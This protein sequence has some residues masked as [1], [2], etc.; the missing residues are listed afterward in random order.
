MIRHAGLQDFDRIIELMANFANAAPLDTYHNPEYNLRGVQNYLVTMIQAGCVLVGEIDEQIQGM[1][2]AQ[3]CPDPW[4]NHV[5]ML[6]EVAWWVE[7]AYR[8][9][10][11]GYRLLHEYIRVGK[12]MQSAGIIDHFVLTTMINSPDL[13]L[14]KRGWR[15]I[16]TNYVY[17]GVA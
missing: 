11:L 14:Q 3:I 9:T 13:N 2:L 10:T 12:A 5:N 6:R 8:H 1:L 17:E 4:L 7:P 15:P 16:E